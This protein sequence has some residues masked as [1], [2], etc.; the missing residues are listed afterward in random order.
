METENF[1]PM[2]TEAVLPSEWKGGDVLIQPKQL[3]EV[4]LNM[5]GVQRMVLVRVQE[6]LLEGR[7]YP[8]ITEENTVKEL[9]V[10]VDLTGIDEAGRKTRLLTQAKKLL[11]MSVAIPYK[12][13][14]MTDGLLAINLFHYINAVQG[15]NIVEFVLTPSSEKLLLCI[16][17]GVKDLSKVSKRTLNSFRGN[18]NVQRLYEILEGEVSKTSFNESAPVVMDIKELAFRFGMSGHAA[19]PTHFVEQVVIPAQGAFY[20]NEDCRFFFT[21]SYVDKFGVKTS[22]YGSRA[23]RIVFQIKFKN[24]EDSYSNRC[25][26]EVRRWIGKLGVPEY[27]VRNAVDNI[28]MSGH[29]RYFASQ[30]FGF[31]DRIAAGK[32][33]SEEHALNCLR[34]DLMNHKI[35][36]DSKNLL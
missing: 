3:L 36:L 16:P 17:N 24:E 23:R 22:E 25:V 19:S 14:S 5:T 18:S 2:L 11:Q 6:A 12:Y 21:T 27:Q 34:K 13:N 26:A 15:S 29:L 4:G 32:L 1:C 35:E 10:S 31:P 8:K 28:V 7:A 20:N 9:A 33:K 30:C